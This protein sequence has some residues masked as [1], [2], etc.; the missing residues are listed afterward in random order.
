MD[1]SK[2]V[3]LIFTAAFLGCVL[4]VGIILGTIAIVRNA[5]SLMVYKGVYL[6]KGVANYLSASYKYDF[7]SALLK[8]G[9]ECYDSEDF[10]QSDAGDGRTYADILIENTEKYIKSVMVG[11]YLFDKNTN[12]TKS[13]KNAIE[14]AIDEV[15]DYRAD[16]SKDRFNE[17]GESMGFDFDDFKE[18]AELLYKSQMAE[19]VIF[20]YEGSSLSSGDFTSECEDYFVNNYARVR[21][22]IIRTD[23]ELV[24]D[25]DTGKEVLAKYDDAQKAEALEKI[26]DI[27]AKIADGRMDE[28]AFIWHIQNEYPTNSVNDT[29]GYYFSSTSAYSINF[30]DQGAPEVVKLALSGK[31]GEFYECE[32]DIGT[33]FIYK[34]ELQSGAYSRYTISHF[35]ED[36]Y[37]NAAP[38]IYE[39]SVDVYISDVTVK[40]KYDRSFVVSQPYNMKL[41]V[42]FR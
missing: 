38:Y 31:V 16:G 19:T 5:R 29:E 25:P 30:A 32:L 28:E 13:D 17:I 26:A 20:G 40:D 2:K 34:T 8:S 12:L 39:K 6:E 36:F 9:V 15:L 11:S 18:A 33:C 23:G 7:M 21:I 37:K 4:L 35:F 41:A 10:W 24:I 22:I 27:R 3:F 1:K 42:K 14:K